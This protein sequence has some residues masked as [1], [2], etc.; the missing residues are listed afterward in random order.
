[1][2]S[3]ER[4]A[5]LRLLQIADS[6][7]PVGAASHSFGLETLVDDGLLTVPSLPELITTLLQ[8]SA[9]VEAVFCIDSHRHGVCGWRHRM[10]EMNARRPAREGREGSIAIGRRLLR[11]A[12]HLDPSIAELPDPHYSCAFGYV[13]GVMGIDEGATVLAFLHQAVAGWISACQ[14]LLPLGQTQAAH[15]AWQVKP[16]IVDTAFRAAQIDPRSAPSFT[17]LL[18]LASMQ[19][20]HLGTRLFIS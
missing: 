18:E 5:F 14:R 12:R 9:L 6:A 15:I 3:H 19:H 2:K 11:L 17:P 20:P 1:M 16:T 13:A 10:A 4:L 8:E 7:V